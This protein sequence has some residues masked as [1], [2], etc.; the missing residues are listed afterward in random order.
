MRIRHF[1]LLLILSGLVYTY[2]Q[3]AI[4][5]QRAIYA[6]NVWADGDDA[7]IGDGLCDVDLLTSGS[8]CT[9]RAAVQEANVNPDFDVIGLPAGT[10]II[11]DDA[12][13]ITG[14][15][16][17]IRGALNNGTIIDGAISDSGQLFVRHGAV[18]TTSRLTFQ[19][20]QGGCFPV[21]G[22]GMGGA[23]TN[24]GDLTLS[25]CTLRQNRTSANGGAVANGH[26]LTMEN[27]LVEDNK[28]GQVGGGIYSAGYN[29]AGTLIVRDSMI[30]DNL[31]SGGG[32][33]YIADT[34]A[35]L[36]NVSIIHNAA[37]G[38][39]A[40]NSY[41][42]GLSIKSSSLTFTVS[43][44]GSTFA[45]NYSEASGGAIFSSNTMLVTR[46]EFRNNRAAQ[47]GGAIFAQLEAPQISRTIFY[48]NWAGYEGG[49]IFQNL[50]DL[51]LE[52]S[53][54]FNNEAV[55]DG[56]GLYINGLQATADNV[57]FSGNVS[58]RFGGAALVRGDLVGNYLTFMDNQAL[59][60]ALFAFDEGSVTL[61][62]SVIGPHSGSF[63]YQP[64][65]TFASDGFN[66]VQAV[67]GCSFS[68]IASDQ[69]NTNPLL[70]PLGD[71]GGPSI[72]LT[73]AL[74]ASSTAVDAG[75]P[76]TCPATDQRGVS[77]PVGGGCDAGAL[78]LDSAIS[79]RTWSP[80]SPLPLFS[81]ATYPTPAPGITLT[82]DSIV[83]AADANI[84]D[85]ICATSG[86]V[87][88]LRAAI[89]E[90]NAMPGQET[91]VLPAGIY[92]INSE[93]PRITDHLIIDGAGPT[94]TS[95]NR[96]TNARALRVEY[97]TIVIIR[98]IAM[99]GAS[100]FVS[101]YGHL[102][103][104][105]CHVADN[106]DSAIFSFYSFADSMPTE[107]PFPI[108][109]VQDCVF[110]NN[111]GAF[112]GAAIQSTGKV[113]VAASRFLNNEATN[114][115][116][117]YTTGSAGVTDAG[118][119]TITDSHFEGNVAANQG[120]AIRSRWS[121]ITITGTTFIDNQAA[122]GSVP[123]GGAIATSSWLTVHDSYFEGN[124]AG[125]TGGAIANGGEWNLDIDPAITNLDRS[126]FINNSADLGGALTFTG[127]GDLNNSTFSGNQAM[128]DGGAILIGANSVGSLQ[129]LTVTDNQADSDDD[130]DGAGG[131]IQ[132]AGGLWDEPGQFTIQ[133]SVVAGNDAFAG[134][135]CSASPGIGASLGFNLIGQMGDC[136]LVTV[137]SDL[138]GIDPELGPLV[139]VQNHN[140]VHLPLPGSVLIDSGGGCGSYDQRDWLR[141]SCD[142]GAAE[143]TIPLT[144]AVDDN[145]AAVDREPG[146]GICETESGSCTFAA[147]VFEASVWNY[148]DEVT[149]PAGTFTSNNV[150][151]FGGDLTLTGAGAQAT[152]L[153]ANLPILRNYRVLQTGTFTDSGQ[154]I[155]LQNLALRGGSTGTSS[156]QSGG[157]IQNY[158]DLT[159]SN[160]LIE[161]NQ[162]GVG[163][164]I[165]NLGAGQLLVQNS[166][167]VGNMA[168]YTVSA[169]DLG[170][171]GALYNS[172][173][174]PVQL[175]NVTISGNDA[176]SYGG[177]IVHNGTG[178][179][180]LSQVT[181]AGNESIF[182]YGGGVA[183]VGT[184][185]MRLQNSILADNLAATS[186]PDCFGSLTISRSQALIETISLNCLLSGSALTGDPNLQRL[187]DNG[188]QTPTHA[189]LTDSPAV[190]A[191]L[192]SCP[193][194][195]QRGFERIGS[196]DLGAFELGAVPTAIGLDQFA[197]L[198][199][200]AWV[201]S[202]AVMLLLSV[203]TGFVLHSYYKYRQNQ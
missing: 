189:L 85:G 156:L 194:I 181:V 114:G 9:F 131:G 112:N 6:V 142:R 73:H 106:S 15:T 115:A 57:T 157:A 53:A 163:G 136:G 91:I 12:I 17:E 39:P 16:L 33:L 122:G 160:V 190:D 38:T 75:D 25:D 201:I 27:C 199:G 80:T 153:S 174:A 107:N 68:A 123:Q 46:T 127:A 128:D 70:G 78:E 47:R 134:P 175:I 140:R 82:V 92:A 135:D 88:T 183:N 30:Q 44:Q 188:G 141:G 100:R 120:G 105:N 86:A 125:Y 93:L 43:I 96:S 3:P 126:A 185:I 59:D 138:I 202:L 176:N 155:T 63:C 130:N 21:Y 26:R 71:N 11:E 62:S 67:I 60:G 23:I 137:A 192:G 20:G 103:V 109:H 28:A 168:D 146:N 64:T 76:T 49:A 72:T 165:A 150:L 22:C 36:D 74:A 42:G 94:L 172:S 116:A 5:A 149:I 4:A 147:A 40:R 182:G 119:L 54:I 99:T 31:S 161:G 124:S 102:T 110:E 19:N 180:V 162:A 101:N 170:H 169:V 184:G 97:S 171:G 48:G 104:E 148:A 133:N 89:A 117:I 98:D 90:S 29:F 77:R 121:R 45:D 41:G 193:T 186:A 143:L 158:A 191:A 69:I 164:G 177:G 152:N 195:D 132:L 35:L 56:G 55:R 1:L 24:N 52:S 95:L 84:G 166:A 200:D 198:Q 79:G 159:L 113:T 139:P 13:E 173:S 81:Y 144:F 61:G 51:N 178:A 10:F 58:G 197:A 196:C 129:N 66:V 167:L 187:A 151:I 8:Q 118:D 7:N 87:C 145:G 18:V 32:G 83:D 34:N 14:G 179:M 2:Q 108:L 65:G 50:V 154:Q 111:T 37:F 203:A